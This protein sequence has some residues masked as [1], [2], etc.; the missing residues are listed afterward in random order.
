[1]RLTYFVRDLHAGLL[2]RLTIEVVVESSRSGSG[3][4]SRGGMHYLLRKSK[5]GNL[6]EG[7]W[8]GDVT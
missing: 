7:R 1:M 3:V 6:L 4:L 2:V 8:K 5:V